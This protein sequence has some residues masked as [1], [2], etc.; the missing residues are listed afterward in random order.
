MIHKKLINK[1]LDYQYYTDDQAL[2][3][4]DWKNSQPTG[5]TI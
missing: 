2:F 4:G 1:K 5:S 3:Y